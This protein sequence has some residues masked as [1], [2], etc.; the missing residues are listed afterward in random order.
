MFVKH[1]ECM[2]IKVLSLAFNCL[3]DGLLNRRQVLLDLRHL[4]VDCGFKGVNFLNHFKL[5][6]S[7]QPCSLAWLPRLLRFGIPSASS[8][9]PARLGLYE[10]TLL[11]SYV[12]LGPHD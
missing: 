12:D 1:I 6:G 7:R 3:S 11:K 9:W 8:W 5:P 4:V 10:C 2:R